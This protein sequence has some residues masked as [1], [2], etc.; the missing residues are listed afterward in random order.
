MPALFHPVWI[1]QYLAGF[2]GFQAGHGFGKIFH[3]DAVGDYG[4]K[5]EASALEQ[6]GHLVP[7]LV[8]AAAIDAL[9]GQAFEDD[10]FGEVELNR[11][12]GE[13]EQRDASAAAHDVEGGADRVG[14]ASHLENH[15]HAQASGFLGD[16]GTYIF[17]G[18]IEGV[19]G[20]HLG[21]QLAP[22]LVDFDGEDGGCAHGSRHRDRKQTDG[23]AAGDG[24]SLRGDF[25][26]Q[27]RVHGVA[28]RIENGRVLLGNH[29]IELPDIRFGDDDVLGESSVGVDADDFH[30]PADVGFARAALQALAA[31]HV[32]FG[33]HEIAFLDAGDF[34]AEGGHLAA[35][36][37]SG[38][39]RR[40][41]ASLSPAVPFKD[42]EIGAADGGD[43]DFAEYV[44]AAVG[45]NFDFADFRA[46]RG[47]RLNH[48][49]HGAR[50]WK[51][52]AWKPPHE[53]G[54]R[55]ANSLF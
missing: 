21:R 45:G 36:F 27:H 12:R 2:T 51:Y 35:E 28:Q 14:M 19:V 34:I 47:F 32:H 48:R 30:I 15:V 7:R 26:R 38:D 6:G 40:M 43:L 17:F 11:F 37:V 33:G 3:R 53:Y 10:V 5:I 54:I 49:E 55:R 39:E 9:N 46:R 8:H 18:W 31:S 52:W 4:V 41:N 1:H 42:V 24:Y 44:G 29:R 22:M 50:H 16:D 20:F 23:A 13:S 25:S